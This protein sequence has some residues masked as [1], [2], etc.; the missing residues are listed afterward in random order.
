MTPKDEKPQGVRKILLMGVF[1]RILF[2]EAVLLVYSLVYRWHLYDADAQDLFWHA[3]RIAILVAIIIA[4][5]MITLKSFLTKKIIAPLEAIAKTNERIRDDGTLEESLI[6][7]ADSPEEIRS[8][9]SS[10]DSMLRRIMDVSE[11]RLQLVNFIKETFGRYL[12]TKVVEE[13]LHS[14]EGR[15]IGG[16]RRVVTILMADLRGFTS[17]SE[18]RDPEEMVTLLNRY[19]EKMSG[20]I[21]K[22]DGII[23]EIIGDAILAVFGA[24]HVHDDDPERAVACAIEMQNCLTGL[25]KELTQAGYPPLEMGIGINTGSVIVGN[26]GSELRMKYGLVGA[27]VN[28]ASRIESNS[29]GGEVL[30]GLSTHEKVSHAV[31]TLPPRTV[32]MKGMKKPLVF[33]SVHRIDH[34]GFGSQV[35]DAPHLDA[36]RMEIQIPF[37]YWAVQGKRVELIPVMG[38]TLSM[39]KTH[40]EVISASPIPALSD[41]KLQLD[42]C[43]DAHCFEEMYAKCISTGQDKGGHKSILRFTSMGEKDRKILDRWMEEL[44]N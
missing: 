39:D 40:M 28:Q 19:L 38:E 31:E 12:S 25:N 27:A 15:K 24:P 1:W 2:I 35:L 37:K 33:Y 10:R 21:L 3:V 34:P 20:I 32:M 9:I 18:N 14:S 16:S 13:I 5:M 43:L 26:I 29:I 23:D 4:F 7:D 22:Y 6:L 41:I 36:G 17:L 11:E 42:F 30:I 8:I 44:S